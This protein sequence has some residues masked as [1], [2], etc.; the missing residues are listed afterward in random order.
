[1]M[2]STP[3]LYSYWRSSSAW[4]VRIALNLKGIKYEYKA[5][6]LLNGEQ[7]SEEYLKT[8]PLG[9][10]PLLDIDGHKLAESLAILE[11]LEETRPTPHALLPK[12]PPHRA[13]VR[14]ITQI[15]ISD[16][17]PLQNVSVL[18]KL[19][20]DQDKKNEWAKYWIDHNF[21]ALEKIL[22]KTAGKYCVGDEITIA[23]CVLVPQVY[24][25]ARFS[26][27]MGKFPIIQRIS[28]E[29]SKHQAFQLAH[30]NAQPDTPKQ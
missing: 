24:N 13:A 4:R 21:E 3:I 30:A 26:V 19:S 29:A 6:N 15:I 16:T 8:N 22:A 17:Q 23:D 10:I 14:Q 20:D 11:Y 18:K 1:V 9:L 28:D 25:A 12:D 27:D 7:K 5:V 2:S